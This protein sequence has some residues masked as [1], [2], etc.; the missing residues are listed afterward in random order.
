MEL[1]NRKVDVINGSDNLE[2][3]HI[4]NNHPAL[5]SCTS[6]E[7]INDFK[8]DLIWQ[9]SKDSGIIQLRNLIPLE[10]LY[11]EPH[12]GMSG[13]LWDQH[14]IDFANF[15]KTFVP[16]S[17]FEIGGGRGNLASIFSKI[18]RVI[19]WTIVEPNPSPDINC[20]AVFIKEFFT[21]NFK[22]NWQFDT[23]VHS[24]V[25][26]H[27]YEPAE[28]IKDISNLLIDNKKM[29][30]SVPNM[31]SMLEH[32]HANCINFEHTVFLSEPYIEYL[33][34]KFKFRILKKSYFKNHSIFYSTI[35]DSTVEPIVLDNNLYTLNK[36][37]YIEYINH[38]NDL[39]IKMN[40]AIK[41]I[42]VPIYLFG[43]HV[44]TQ[45]LIALGLDV[46]NV[47]N[48]LD[49]DKSKHGKRLYGTSLIVKSP[50]LLHTGTPVALIVK[51]GMYDEEIRNHIVKHINS[52]V[53]FI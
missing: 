18:T 21:E 14:Y 33:L 25:F 13:L 1:I 10:L 32:K 19:P 44:F 47:I 36:V 16:Q 2:T 38:F 31:K 24:H 8:T 41:Q 53:I 42:T 49:H 37:A 12:T 17:V 34:A 50:Y 4:V 27:S 40:E 35:K 48:I 9:I 43:A 26:E 39:I 30:F 46:T 15:I 5:M 45:Y 6:Q 23:V 29:I 7:E 3:L 22:P 11:S 51:S 52:N 28:F 20:S